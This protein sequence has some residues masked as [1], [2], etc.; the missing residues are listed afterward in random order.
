[1]DAPIIAWCIAEYKA[2]VIRKTG[3]IKLFATIR[4]LL[5]PDN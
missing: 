1:M 5:A 4:R 3:L 2:F